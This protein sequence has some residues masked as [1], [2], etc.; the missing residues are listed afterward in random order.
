MQGGLKI[1]M[2]CIRNVSSVQSKSRSA[3]RNYTDSNDEEDVYRAPQV[4]LLYKCW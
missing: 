4:I 3:M 2:L 1:S